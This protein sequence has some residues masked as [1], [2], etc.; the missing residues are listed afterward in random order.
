MPYG[1]N[2]YTILRTIP[3]PAMS[4]D[5]PATLSQGDATRFVRV[6]VR[7]RGGTLL[8]LAIDVVDVQS[9]TVT[10]N[11]YELGVGE[12]DAI[13]LAPGQRLYAVS[14]GAA[15]RASVARSVAIPMHF[16]EA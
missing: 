13:P 5:A 4:T 2:D 14:V 12:S 11:T 15:G 6:L 10:P 7:N 8:R 3:V 9:L 1:T 16:M